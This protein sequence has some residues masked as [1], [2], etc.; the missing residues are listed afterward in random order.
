MKNAMGLG[1]ALVLGALPLGCG[2]GTAAAP[3]PGTPT[4]K[5]EVA[6]SK[7]LT[8]FQRARLLG[9]YSTENG[10]SGFLLDRT[11]PAPRARL[12]GST[13]VETLAERGSVAGAIELTSKHVWLRIDKESG[14]V[15]LFQ[16]PQQTQGVRV[17]RDADAEPLQ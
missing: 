17:V 8:S 5:E 4:A 1:L 6:D 7:H 15:L 13:E 9:H 10:K 2:G 3:T 11:G 16:G 14:D 12:D